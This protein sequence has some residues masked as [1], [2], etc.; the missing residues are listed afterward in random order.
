MDQRK[1]GAAG[2]IAVVVPYGG[3]MNE[4]ASLRKRLA[5][6]RVGERDRIVIAVNSPQEPQF[7]EENDGIQVVH[8]NRRGSSYYARNVGAAATQAEWILFLDD[9]CRYGPDLIER[10][11]R[12]LP[13][14][15]ESIGAVAGIIEA[16]ATTSTIEEYA[17]SRGHLD[18]RNAYGA[19]PPFGATAHLLVRRSCWEQ[20]GG[21]DGEVFSGGDQAF[22]IEIVAAGWNLGLETSVSV[23]HDHRATFRALWRQFHKYGSGRHWLYSKYPDIVGRPRYFAPIV[24][25]VGRTVRAI[26]VKRSSKQVKFALLDLVCELALLAGSFRDNGPKWSLSRKAP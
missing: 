6:L 11:V 2:S 9:D 1:V 5:D 25:S 19:Q 24:R 7:A 13:S 22:C 8:A 4:L 20:V 26:A 18:A 10:W 23:A 12:R 21:F 15:E 14:Y 3:G 17:D 16:S